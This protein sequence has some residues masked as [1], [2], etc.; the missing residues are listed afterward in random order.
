VINLAQNIA[1]LILTAGL[2]F[3]GMSIRAL[4]KIMTLRFNRCQTCGA[5]NDE[6]GVCIRVSEHTIRTCRCD[7]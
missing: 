1:I 4:H 2:F 5:M 3:A 6:N 7:T